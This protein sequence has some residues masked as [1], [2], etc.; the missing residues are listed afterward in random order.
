[1]TVAGRRVRHRLL[2]RDRAG[3]LRAYAWHDRAGRG[4]AGAAARGFDAC[5]CWPQATLRTAAAAR[6]RS[7]SRSCARRRARTP[8]TPSRSIKALHEAAR[9][10]RCASATSTGTRASSIARE[11]RE[12]D[13]V[14]RIL[15]PVA[16]YAASTFVERG[17]AEDRLAVHRFGC[18]L[19]RVPARRAPRRRPPDG[20]VRRRGEPAKGLHHGAACV[21]GLRRGGR[22]A[23]SAR[24]HDRRRLPG[25]TLGAAARRSPASRSAASSPTSRRADA[26]DRRPAAAE[27]QRGQRARHLRG[28][29]RRLRARSSATPPA[30]RRS[31]RSTGS[32]IR[33]ATRQR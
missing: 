20:R 7:A 29:G 30:R 1:M 22:G 17:V 15:V 5:R 9:D 23:A 25:A 28:A 26:P 14:D 19:E 4:A 3:A 6:P 33:P 11:E 2:G 18:D 31:T 21:A 12:Y 13:A 8:R 16:R 24:G 32:S 27:P 10:R